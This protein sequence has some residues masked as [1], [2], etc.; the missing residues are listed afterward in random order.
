MFITELQLF[1]H[2]TAGINWPFYKYSRQACHHLKQVAVMVGVMEMQ[3]PAGWAEVLHQT[4]SSQATICVRKP[5]KCPRD[6][7]FTFQWVT[8]FEEISL[9]VLRILTPGPWL[10][11]MMTLWW[12]Q[13][14]GVAMIS[15][16]WCEINVWLHL[17]TLWNELGQGDHTF[18]KI[19]V[20]CSPTVSFKF[21]H[22]PVSSVSFTVLHY[23]GM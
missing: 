4:E 15:Q 6:C 8:C 12:R 11:C 22:P 20:Y 3:I 16:C 10:Y 19:T 9:K 14:Y 21:Q 23:I 1:F 13:T 7:P 18:Q 5:H 17:F 2:I